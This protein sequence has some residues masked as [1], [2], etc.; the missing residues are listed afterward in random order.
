M[1]SGKNILKML[2]GIIVIIIGIIWYTGVYGL[3]GY[4]NDLLI[5]LKGTVGLFLLFVGFIVAWMGYDDYKM[6]REMAAEQKKEPEEPEA[7]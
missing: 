6:D 5:L 7:G 1:S 4:W 2:L 3:L